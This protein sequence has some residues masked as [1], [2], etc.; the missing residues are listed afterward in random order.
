MISRLQ[1]YVGEAHPALANVSAGRS[2][3][4][5][6]ISSG[7]ERGVQSP[8][9]PTR[10][11]STSAA[12]VLALSCQLL[13]SQWRLLPRRKRSFCTARRIYALYYSPPTHLYIPM[14]D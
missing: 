3:Y 6:M 7:I 8:T 2:P 4:S 1:I 10:F 12:A 11:L 5:W 9:L 14:S 13:L